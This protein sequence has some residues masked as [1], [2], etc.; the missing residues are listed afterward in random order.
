MCV[1]STR[2]I[3]TPASPAAVEVRLDRERRVDHD[4]LAGGG[5]ADEVG[6]AAEVV[7]DELPEDTVTSIGAA[8]S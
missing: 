1:S 6:A 5:V 4:R 2:T 7:V 8:A 3:R